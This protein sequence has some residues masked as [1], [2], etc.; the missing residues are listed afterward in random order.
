LNG[1]SE[2][3]EK[4][5]R[6]LRLVVRYGGKG[7]NR[8]NENDEGRLDFGEVIKKSRSQRLAGGL[9]KWSG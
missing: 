5:P 1:N 6:T 8:T 9:S 4:K 3:E 7:M 2:R